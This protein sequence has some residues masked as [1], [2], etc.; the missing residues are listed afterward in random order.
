MARISREELKY[1]REQNECFDCHS[2]DV[3][4]PAAK[5][6]RRAQLEVPCCWRHWYAYKSKTNQANAEKYARRS[7]AKRQAGQCVCP[8]CHNKLIPQELLPPWIRESTC[9]MHG[10]LKAFRVNRAAM[11]QFI[12]EHCL[13]DEERKDMTAQNII[14]KPGG[15]FVWFGAQHPG[16][17]HTKGFSARDLLR[18][19]K[20]VPQQ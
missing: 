7:A 18:R 15:D 5:L 19:Y 17:Y 14:Y 3:V 20:Q 12:I 13:S 16:Y 4:N 6:Q 8:G 1:C 9:G 2:D 11:V 10:A